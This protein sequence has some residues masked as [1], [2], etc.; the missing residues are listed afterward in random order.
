MRVLCMKI[1]L[2]VNSLR[3]VSKNRFSF[4]LKKPKVINLDTEV[5]CLGSSA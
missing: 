3:L 1:G 4:V 2:R 5:L